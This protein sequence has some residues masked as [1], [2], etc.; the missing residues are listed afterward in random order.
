MDESN[1]NSREVNI[2]FAESS[3]IWK[4]QTEQLI[5][6]ETWD[7]IWTTRQEASYLL[8]WW[9]SSP[10]SYYYNLG[11]D[12]KNKESIYEWVNKIAYVLWLDELKTWDSLNIYF[13]PMRQR[14][15]DKNCLYHLLS[16]LMEHWVPLDVVLKKLS[17]TSFDST[18]HIAYGPRDIKNAVI[19]W[20]KTDIECNGK[21]YNFWEFVQEADFLTFDSKSANEVWNT[22]LWVVWE[23]LQFLVAN[24]ENDIAKRLWKTMAEFLWDDYD[25]VLNLF[26]Y[27]PFRGEIWHEQASM[28]ELQ[29]E[30]K[31]KD[32]L[33]SKVE[34]INFAKLSYIAPL[35]SKLYLRLAV[36]DQLKSQ[37]LDHIL[38]DWDKISA[39]YD[40][41]IS[42][43][44]EEIEDKI[45]GQ[46][47][48]KDREFYV[49]RNNTENGIVMDFNAS[50]LDTMS[51]HFW[52]V[53]WILTEENLRDIWLLK[54]WEVINETRP[55]SMILPGYNVRIK[56]EWD[57]IKV[58]NSENDKHLLFTAEVGKPLLIDLDDESDNTKLIRRRWSFVIPDEDKEIDAWSFP[59]RKEWIDSHMEAPQTHVWGVSISLKASI[60]EHIA[61]RIAKMLI[62]LPDE[63]IINDF[64]NAFQTKP[65]A[66]TWKSI[67]K[68]G[69]FN[70]SNL[71]W[72][73]WEMTQF[74][75]AD[76][77]E[78]L[79]KDSTWNIRRP[80][81]EIV[82]ARYSA[83]SIAITTVESIDWV[84]ISWHKFI[85][86]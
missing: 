3:E 15:M 83:S 81:I 5:S 32:I 43:I 8:Q 30:W 28:K 74:N 7:V 34:D 64:K 21:T 54:T 41:D 12:F 27:L 72:I 6:K 47:Y 40:I 62:N 48:G 25:A 67:S 66:E 35:L 78:E 16:A 19:N 50:H 4:H 75:V 44:T 9:E 63:S 70:P 85:L 86:A 53:A 57:S 51:L 76:N 60:K 29:Q 65:N 59:H 46:K 45:K 10:N 69:K 18:S 80:D 79:L 73:F 22:F 17:I 24:P 68:L 33:N 42:N 82:D 36:H 23:F 13:N 39:S 52:I 49:E 26:Q 55:E 1:R 38:F 31:L 14:W 56:R 61:M 20:A 71:Q 2:V 37:D 84:K 77:Y 58:Y 11:I